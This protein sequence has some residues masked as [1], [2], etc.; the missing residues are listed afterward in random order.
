M[1]N[2]DVGFLMYRAASSVWYGTLQVTYIE[3][4]RGLS[5]QE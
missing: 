1:T 3:V 4:K 2:N 5:N